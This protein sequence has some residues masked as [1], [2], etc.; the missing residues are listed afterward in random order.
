MGEIEKL[1]TMSGCYSETWRMRLVV[2][3]S[4][5]ILNRIWPRKE[6]KSV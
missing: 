4:A 5:A 1:S 3:M 6:V 2:S